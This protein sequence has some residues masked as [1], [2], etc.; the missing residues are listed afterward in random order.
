MQRQRSASQ[1]ALCGIIACGLVAAAGPARAEGRGG[2]DGRMFMGVRYANPHIAMETGF[3]RWTGGVVTEQSSF[4]NDYH[5]DA[6][7]IFVGYTLPYRKMYLSG[8]VF[9]DRYDGEFELAVGSSKFTNSIN[10]AVG[11]DLMP[12]VYLA[13]KL[14]AFAR[15]GVVSGDCDFIK[16]SPTSTN[17]DENSTLYGYTWGF[18]LA[19]DVTPRVT[20]K[21]DYA[22]TVYEQIEINASRGTRD[23]RTLVEPHAK[24][25]SLTLQYNFN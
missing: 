9:L 7:G 17:Y 14:S 24:S 15:L 12:G 18:G 5:A 19:Y 23:D 8:Q 1:L 3:T 4:D 16:Q 21:L 10:H 11:L 20:A 25:V 6:G 22:Q 13:E 2:F